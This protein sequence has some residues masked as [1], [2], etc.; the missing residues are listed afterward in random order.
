[1]GITTGKSSSAQLK[2]E[3]LVPARDLKEACPV[4]ITR[5]KSSSAQLNKWEGLVPA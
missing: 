3:G 4:G 5:G 1:M 2:W